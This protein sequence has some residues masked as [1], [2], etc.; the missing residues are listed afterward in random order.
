VLP[1]S[2]SIGLVS[3]R[4][5]RRFAI[6]RSTV[7]VFS[8]TLIACMGC[9]ESKGPVS[10]SPEP[11]S[12]SNSPQ[13]EA[14]SDVLA[15]ILQRAKAGDVDTAIQQFVSGAPDNWIE[16]TGL[17]DLRM[18]EAAFAKVDAAEKSRLQQQFIDRVGEIKGFARTVIDRANAAKQKGDMETATRY[19]EAVNRLGRELRDADIVTVYQQTGEALAEMKLSE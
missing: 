19:L 10:P 5:V 9:G 12:V 7:I 1:L 15:D 2:R 16:S 11:S 6:L 8:A 14:K 13:A 18:S 4:P 3:R 17:E